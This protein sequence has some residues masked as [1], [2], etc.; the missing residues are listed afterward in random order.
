MENTEQNLSPP[1]ANNN[2]VVHNIDS[3]SLDEILDENKRRNAA[4]KSTYDP[5]TG[6]GCCNSRV[7]YPFQGDDGTTH[8][9]LIP[10][11]MAAELESTPVA[12]PHDVQ[13]LRL[14]HDFEYWCATCVTILDKMSGKFVK[15]KLNRPQRRILQVLESQRLANKPLRLIMLK[16]R[17]WGGST[18]VQIYMIWIQL[19]LKKNWNSLIC[20]I[21]RAHV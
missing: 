5:I 13:L 16:A 3:L 10:E 19:V 8:E 12:S 4:L 6:V 21:G 2:K 15:F 17:Q 11:A 18:L 20:E 9:H 14:R 1:K 7:P